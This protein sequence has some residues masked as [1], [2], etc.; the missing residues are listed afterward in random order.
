MNRIYY[1]CKANK[2]TINEAKTKYM[3]VAN[4]NI[5]PMRNISIANSVLGKVNHYEYLGMMLENKLSMDGQLETIK[6]PR[7][8][9]SFTCF[10]SSPPILKTV[11]LQS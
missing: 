5:E 7:Y 1:W 4:S 10:I 2:L 6:M 8:R 11:L 9:Y 3:I